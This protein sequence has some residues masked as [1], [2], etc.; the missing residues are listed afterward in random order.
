MKKIGLICLAVV[1]ALGIA[2]VGFGWWNETLDIG[3][4]PVTTGEAKVSW[5]ITY[6][7]PYISLY[8][9]GKADHWGDYSVSADGHTLTISMGNMYPCAEVK[10]YPE[11]HN[12]GTIP[13]KVNGFTVSKTGGSDDLWNC[14]EVRYSLVHKPS[15]QVVVFHTA[16]MDIANLQAHLN[17]NGTTYPYPPGPHGSGPGVVLLPGEYLTFDEETMT[18]HVKSSCVDAENTSVQFDIVVNFTQFNAP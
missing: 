11:L 1:L 8:N 13:V 10:F 3:Q 2:G 6:C 7:S 9:A 4:N 14:L 17:A 15:G 5:N 16:Y 12:T 18:F